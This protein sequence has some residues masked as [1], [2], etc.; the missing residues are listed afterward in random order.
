[1]ARLRSLGY[2]GGSYEETFAL[3][4]DKQDPKDFA[5]V[6]AKLE[7]LD[8]CVRYEDRAGAR[9]AGQEILALRPDLVQVHHTL[10]Q[11]AIEEGDFEAAVRHYT[12]ALRLDPESVRA[13]SWYYNL[14]MLMT[15]TGRLEE[16]A[17]YYQRAIRE[18]RRE[19]GSS[20]NPNRL[21]QSARSLLFSLHDNLGNILLHQGKFDEAVSEYRSALRIKP[22]DA[23]AHYELGIA[24]ARLG[25][26]NEA[27]AAFREVVRLA[28]NHARARQ[29]L[30]A[31]SRQQG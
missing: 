27:S 15:H 21:G 18:A 2:T 13:V 4:S 12:E 6:Y 9:Q 10:G 25:R 26:R 22:N 14:G 3:D 20:L 31:I 16:A 8:D 5:E 24:W 11:V 30:E 19:G 7:I 1:M 17:E 29:A 23:Q 28:P